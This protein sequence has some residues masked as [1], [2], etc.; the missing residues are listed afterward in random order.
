MS[1]FYIIIEFVDESGVRGLF[2]THEKFPSLV[3][4]HRAYLN[5]MKVQKSG[6]ENLTKNYGSMDK[7][8]L[9]AQAHAL[10]QETLSTLGWR[11]G[12]GS[13]LKYLAFGRH[14]LREK[15]DVSTGEDAGDWKG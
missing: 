6:G 2:K 15:Q 7:H 14:L 3:G 10:G 1:T 11:S 5:T 8:G 13:T 4:K 12:R 9:E